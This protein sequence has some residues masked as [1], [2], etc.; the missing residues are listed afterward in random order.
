MENTNG[1]SIQIDSIQ[2]TNGFWRQKQNINTLVTIDAIYARLKEE[3]KIDVLTCNWKPGDKYKPHIFW[4]S[5]VAK[6]IEGAAYVMAEQKN[7]T[8]EK[9]IDEIISF[10]EI[11]QR[12]DGYFNSYFNTVETEERWKRRGDHELYGAGHLI[13]SAIAYYQAT[14]KKKFISMMCKYADHIYKIFIEDA[15]A[16]FETPAHEEI[17]LALYRLHKETRIEKY[18]ELSLFFINKRGKSKKDKNCEEGQWGFLFKGDNTYA[19]DHLPLKE[20]HTAEGHAVRQMYICSAMADIAYENDDREF[21]KAC[22]EVWNDAVN[23]KMYITGGIGSISGIEGFA[24]GEYLPNHMAYTETCAAIGLVFF[25]FRMLKMEVRGEYGDIIEKALYNGILSG[26]SCEGDEFF[27]QNVL[28]AKPEITEYL[29]TRTV[30]QYFPQYKRQKTHE[31]FCCPTNIIRILGS[32]GNYLY[33]YSEGTIYVHLYAES[34]AEIPLSSGKTMI[35]QKTDYPWDGEVAIEI[36]AEEEKEITIALR[37]PGWSMG[38]EVC[39]DEK[40]SHNTLRVI[41]NG[42]LNIQI[43]ICEIEVKESYL[44]IKKI[45]SKGDVIKLNFP[46]PVVE[47]EANPSVSFDCGRVALMRGPLVYCL[48]EVDNGTNLADVAIPANAQYSVLDRDGMKI[49]NTVGLRR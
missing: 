49:L 31:T 30:P 27:Y 33:T 8:L 36:E 29:N 45:W 34:I 7:T 32:L 14:G 4:D 43:D 24:P 11:G 15:S 46:M 6:W 26:V 13:E 12:E 28:E 22:K 9:R 44:Y 35:M 1:K 17:E 16:E 25:S 40:Q 21:F 38:T 23:H 5:D 41:H 37:L 3:G 47:M 20:Q 19:Q 48:E 2:L 10:I 39:I 18:L 42:K